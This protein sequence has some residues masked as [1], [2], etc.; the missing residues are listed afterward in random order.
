VKHK[1]KY[2][3]KVN[4][5][6]QLSSGNYLN[7]YYHVWGRVY[8]T[9]CPAW[10]PAPLASAQ[11]SS[12]SP[13][14]TLT[15]WLTHWRSVLTPWACTH[16]YNIDTNGQFGGL[17]LKTASSCFLSCTTNLVF[18]VFWIN[19]NWL[20]I[21]SPPANLYRIK[22]LNVS[23]L[24]HFDSSSSAAARVPLQAQF[25]VHVPEVGE[26]TA[27]APPTPAVAEEAEL[28][29]EQITWFHTTFHCI[30]NRQIDC[31]RQ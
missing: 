10:C 15:D 17:L 31:L 20:L 5:W 7:L 16:I 2:I 6:I 24:L 25:T 11:S 4:W 14:G 8:P 21:L 19:C 13:V 28:P 30:L 18:G 3:Q 23:L 1:E 9:A 26:Q 12:S 22:L 29:K 27:A